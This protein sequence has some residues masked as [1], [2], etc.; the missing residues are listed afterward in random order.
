MRDQFEAHLEAVYARVAA[1]RLAHIQASNRAIKAGLNPMSIPVPT[2]R[3]D[4]S[5]LGQRGQQ[6]TA[7][8][9][10]GN[11]VRTKA[12]Y[13]VEEFRRHRAQA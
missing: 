7:N 11:I 12:L 5:D 8:A 6:G 2:I 1:I 10:S 3:E 4:G 9:I 13:R